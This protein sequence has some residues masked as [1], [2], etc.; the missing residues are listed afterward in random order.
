LFQ[1]L[2]LTDPNK[3][4]A[5]YD[6]TELARPSFKWWGCIHRHFRRWPE[7][8]ILDIY[9]FCCRNTR[10]R[11]HLWLRFSRGSFTMRVVAGF[12]AAI[13]WFVQHNEDEL[14]ARAIVAYRQ[15]RKRG[16]ARTLARFHLH[17]LRAIS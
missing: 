15:Y 14:R 13:G 8:N 12:I 5:F 4:V 7:A 1:A 9:C 16:T 3:Q 2:D 10:R 11:S 6:E 17:V